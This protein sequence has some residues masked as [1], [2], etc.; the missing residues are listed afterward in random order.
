M[1][2]I[3]KSTDSIIT[4]SSSVVTIGSWKFH[5]TSLGDVQITWSDADGKPYTAI[6]KD[7]FYFPNSPFN[8]L[9][10]TAFSAQLND[11]DRTWI[12]TTRHQSI[13]VWDNENLPRLVHPTSKLPQ[14]T[15]NN[16]FLSFTSVCKF[17]EI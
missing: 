6:L 4:A 5:P 17:L 9:S 14:M 16:G 2:F 7:I 11:D 1:W 15:A 12:K 13:F 10:V 8:V 3:S